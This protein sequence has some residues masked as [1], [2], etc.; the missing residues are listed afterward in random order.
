VGIKQSK[1]RLRLPMS[2]SKWAEAMIA[3]YG[4]TVLPVTTDVAVTAATLPMI[5]TDPFD[6]L[7]I[8]TAQVNKTDIITRDAK[9]AEY[10]NLRVIW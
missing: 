1:K 9:F 2:L 10:P 4:L 8:A 7:I 6:R 5:H 3:K